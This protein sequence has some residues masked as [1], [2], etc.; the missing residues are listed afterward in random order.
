MEKYWAENFS[1]FMQ[2]ALIQVYI[3]YFDLIMMTYV[4]FA[5][6]KPVSRSLKTLSTAGRALKM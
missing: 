2:N 4:V 5:L 6:V 3:D 1:F